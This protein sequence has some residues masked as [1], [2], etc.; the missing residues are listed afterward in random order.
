MLLFFFSMFLS[1]CLIEGFSL[2]KKKQRKEF[3]TFSIMVGAAVFFYI[4]S[5]LGLPSIMELIDRLLKPLG[6][7][8]FRSF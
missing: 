2:Y 1:I 8:I 4:S 3:I 7:T 6:E 5:K